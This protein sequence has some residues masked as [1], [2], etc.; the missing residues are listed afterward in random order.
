MLKAVGGN[1]ILKLIEQEA[2]TSSGIILPTQSL[3]KPIKGIVIDCNESYFL[4]DGITKKVEVEVGD[5]VYFGK[6]HGTEVHY[7]GEKYHVIREEFIYCK[8][9]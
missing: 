9:A 8:E 4:A 1:V 7:N 3:E 6:G 2:K 5:I